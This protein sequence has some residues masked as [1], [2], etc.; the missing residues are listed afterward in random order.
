KNMAMLTPIP[1]YMKDKPI[2]EFLIFSMRTSLYNG[3]MIELNG[4]SIEN[5]NNAKMKEDNFVLVLQ[6]YQPASAEKTTMTETLK[7][8]KKIV[9]NKLLI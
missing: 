7:V 8:D 5:M 3:I 4:I 2:R 9:L 1:A 6:S